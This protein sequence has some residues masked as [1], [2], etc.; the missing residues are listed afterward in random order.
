MRNRETRIKVHSIHVIYTWNKVSRIQGTKLILCNSIICCLCSLLRLLLYL[1]WQN[2]PPRLQSTNNSNPHRTA[3]T[4]WCL[5]H[6]ASHFHTSLMIH[7]EAEL[8]CMNILKSEWTKVE[9]QRR[10]DHAVWGDY[11]PAGIVA[12]LH[13]CTTILYAYQ[14]RDRDSTPITANLAHCTLHILGSC[15]VNV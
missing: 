6:F 5:K 7:A 8:Q 15:H 12:F 11:K 2:T 14:C 13:H 10:A 1:M 3:R 4:T 9:P